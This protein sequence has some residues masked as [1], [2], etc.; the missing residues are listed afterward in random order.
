MVSYRGPGSEP[1][2]LGGVG[3]RRWQHRDTATA[4]AVVG[5]GAEDATGED[6][7]DR[8]CC[9]PARPAD[10]PALRSSSSPPAVAGARAGQD[11]TRYL[12]LVAVSGPA[13]LSLQSR[14]PAH[15]MNWTLVHPAPA[16]AGT[17][18][19][20]Q[21]GTPH[22]V[23]SHRTREKSGLVPKSHDLPR[24]VCGSACQYDL[25]QLKM[26]QVRNTTRYTPKLLSKHLTER[27]WSYNPAT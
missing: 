5:V 16:P 26:N 7:V 15:D 24:K 23:L 18:P 4:F 27:Y 22:R 2:H 9:G 13:P 21:P 6:A 14:N 3:H 12:I 1:D 19:T 17:P 11:P 8:C 10:H 20:L 25:A